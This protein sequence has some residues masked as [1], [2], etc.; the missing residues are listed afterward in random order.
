MAMHISIVICTCNR[1][2]S[3]NKT[4]ESLRSMI[5]PK[6][7][8]W[9]VVVVD[10]NSADG[11]SK[12]VKDLSKKGSL[13]LTYLYE[14][15]QGK[16]FALNRGLKIVSGEIVAF[17][18][19]DVV[20]DR[21]WLEAVL[22]AT[23]QYQDCD[24]FGGRIVSIWDINLPK[25]LGTTE[26]YNCLKGTGYMRDDGT[27]DKDYSKTDNKVP[28]GAN[29]FFRKHALQENGFFRVDLGPLEGKP[30]AAED[31]EYC[32]RMLERGKQF[33]YIAKALIRHRVEKE[34]L[35]KSYLT[36]WRYYCARSEVRR[37]RI[38]DSTICYS[39]VPKYL[40]KQLCESFVRWNI[41][42]NPKKRFYERLRFFWALGEIMETYK[43]A[44]SHYGS[45]GEYSGAI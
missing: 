43:L 45:A 30:G 4:L 17:M 35:T 20:V 22:E 21:G 31:T 24:G 3:L 25:W 41:G 29:M 42:L 13:N 19:D 34:K 44:K 16:S 33:M 27:E 11:T 15:K 1:A 40:F 12:T 39:N 32:F 10:N 26:P 6:G 7:I 23:R 18:D 8:A 37:R 28:C 9:E 38:S 36:R 2:A 5:I 14:R